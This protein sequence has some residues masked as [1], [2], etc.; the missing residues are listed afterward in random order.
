MLYLFTAK[1]QLQLIYEED[2][3]PPRVDFCQLSASLYPVK[4]VTYKKLYTVQ[5]FQSF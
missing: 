2:L 4:L 1:K 5:D 3:I